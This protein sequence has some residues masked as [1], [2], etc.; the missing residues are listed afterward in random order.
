MEYEN[1]AICKK[2]Q[3]KCCKAYAG[4]AYPADFDKDLRPMIIAKR[5]ATA[6]KSGQWAIDY[7]EGD[8]KGIDCP[9]FIRP[10]HKNAPGKLIDPSW[11]GECI[12]LTESGCKLEYTDRPYGCRN[13]EPITD[14]CKYHGIESNDQKEDA[15]LVWIPYQDIIEKTIK[16]MED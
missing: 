3:G 10:A 15:A 9:R 13:L 8:L 11:G 4:I 7:W 12:F 5:I 14:N 2:C 16:I 1:K 6:L